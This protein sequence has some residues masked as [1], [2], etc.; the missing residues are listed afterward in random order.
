MDPVFTTTTKVQ[1]LPLA[2]GRQQQISRAAARE[3]TVLFMPAQEI[4]LSLN[5][6]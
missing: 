6:C 5:F 4:E 3:R 1:L 2:A